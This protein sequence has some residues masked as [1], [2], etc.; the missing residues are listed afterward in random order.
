M[1]PYLRAKQGP[2]FQEKVC[3]NPVPHDS[4]EK[5]TG[6][7]VGVFNAK[8]TLPRYHYEVG[9]YEEETITRKMNFEDKRGFLISGSIPDAILKV[10][11][12]SYYVDGAYSNFYEL[13]GMEIEF[14]ARSYRSWHTPDIG[15]F[16][17]PKKA[18]VLKYPNHWGRPELGPETKEE[19]LARIGDID[20]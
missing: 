13:K 18:V 11:H 3:D 4:R 7:I 10:W 8:Y 1:N 17:I 9:E 6:K 2:A 5:F 20:A 15:T 16:K 12:E 14:V 19:Y